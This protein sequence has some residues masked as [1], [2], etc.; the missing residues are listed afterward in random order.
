MHVHRM[1]HDMWKLETCRSMLTSELDWSISVFI[2]VYPERVV[3]V[4]VML[5]VCYPSP[6]LQLSRPPPST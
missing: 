2:S 6:L 1:V 4:W 5:S 3:A